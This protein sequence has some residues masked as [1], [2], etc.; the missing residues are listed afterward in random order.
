MYIYRNTLNK[1]VWNEIGVV[2]SAS[3]ACKFLREKVSHTSFKRHF[4]YTIHG[5][6]CAWVFFL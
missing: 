1:C 2:P 5:F 4:L 3:N 6:H